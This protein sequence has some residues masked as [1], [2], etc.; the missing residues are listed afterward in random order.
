[1]KLT[2]ATCGLVDIPTAGLAFTWSNRRTDV[3]LDRALG[4]LAW[5]E[6]WQAPDF[7]HLVKA[8]WDGLQ[9]YGC[10]IFVLC[11]KLH[12][13]KVMLK[14]GN[15][16]HFGVH[17]QVDAARH[18]L[19]VIQ[20]EIMDLGL[21]EDRDKSRV[22]WLKD[23]DRNTS[24]LH[25]MV[26]GIIDSGLVERVIPYL[27]RAKEN[28]SLISIPTDEEISLVVRSMD[29]SSSPGLDGFGEGF[30]KACWSVVSGDVILAVQDFFE[31]GHLPPHF[32]SNMLILIPKVLEV[33]GISDYHYAKSGI[34]RQT[35]TVV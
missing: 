3:R 8:F 6:A 33:E 10:L 7:I 30:F 28:L 32:N 27:V 1:M 18:D 34:K 22:R 19:D 13:L 2:C 16:A 25:N 11:S 31:M 23:G 24:F 29:S 12:A 5:L 14:T 17:A 21:S 9:F 4:N 26:K 15:K 35:E 20:V